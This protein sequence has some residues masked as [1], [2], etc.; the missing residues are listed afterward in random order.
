MLKSGAPIDLLVT[1][2]IIRIMIMTMMIITI[3]ILIMIVT[4][5]E[6]RETKR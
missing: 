6:E 4:F 1:L 2:K 3:I 5:R